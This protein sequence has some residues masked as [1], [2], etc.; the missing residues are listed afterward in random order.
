MTRTSRWLAMLS[1][2]LLFIAV[3]GC[4]DD[5]EVIQTLPVS[6]DQAANLIVEVV[7]EIF[8]F[9]EVI[10]DLLEAA[11][12]GKSG[13]MSRQP[14]C[15]PLPG[16]ETDY[17]CTDPE[18]GEICP[19]DET[20]TEWVFN[21]C[22]QAE[23][24]DPGTLDG[25]VTV[26][27]SGNTFDLVF[28]LDVDG[29]PMTGDLTIVLGDPCVTATYTDFEFETD[30]ASTTIDGSTTICPE[31]ASGNLDVVVNA[32]GIQRFLMQISFYEGV[33]TIVIV[34]PSTMLPLYT[35]TFIPLNQT[36][37]CFTY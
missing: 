6:G 11:S 21:S 33:P 4:S 25:T 10:A 3:G 27:Q 37:Q 16:L 23:G 17:F 12:A 15:T 2:A 36:A 35:C 14:T 7:P 26:T 28:N 1:I 18:D 13:N 30:S 24:D 31:S 20:T 29:G 9:G 5:D 8:G 32:P 19:V 34:N 22:V